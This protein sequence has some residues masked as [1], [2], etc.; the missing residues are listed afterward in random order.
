MKN[1]YFVISIKED[2]KNY[3]YVIKTNKNDNILYKINVKNA[4]FVLLADTK[5]E[6]YKIAEN[7]NQ[8]FKNNG[9]Y[10][11]DTPTF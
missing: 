6:A 3:A 9:S 1:K 10:L 11:F 5:K 4:N 8:S 2:Q 7:W